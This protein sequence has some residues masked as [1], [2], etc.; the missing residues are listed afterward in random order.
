MEGVWEG[1]YKVTVASFTLLAG[2][3]CQ[4]SEVRQL[5]STCALLQ[6]VHTAEM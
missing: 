4:T 2:L 1:G 5:F 3:V 6:R